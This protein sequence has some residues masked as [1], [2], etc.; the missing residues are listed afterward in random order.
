[1]LAESI[2]KLII[3]QVR[4]SLDNKGAGN[5]SIHPQIHHFYDQSQEWRVE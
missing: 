1:V 2:K 3:M 4:F 5:N